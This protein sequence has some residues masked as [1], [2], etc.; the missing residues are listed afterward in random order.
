MNSRGP[1]PVA[2]FGQEA[3]K[4]VKVRTTQVAVL[5]AEEEVPGRAGT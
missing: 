5:L 1:R 3:Y 2:V 4:E